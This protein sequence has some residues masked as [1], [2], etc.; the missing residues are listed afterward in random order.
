[1]PILREAGL[2]QEVNLHCPATA[3][4]RERLAKENPD[5]CYAYSLGY[6][7]DQQRLCGLR[8]DPNQMHNDLLPLMADEPDTADDTR[9]GSP[10][11]GR[12]LNVLYVG[13]H[14]WYRQHPTAG[15]HNDHIFL[16]QNNQPHAGHHPWDSVLGCDTDKP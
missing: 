7:D 4:A 3:E 6:R 11:H 10:N 14:V 12:G 13:G 15:V 16:N 5:P 8:R 2:G 9:G 1:M